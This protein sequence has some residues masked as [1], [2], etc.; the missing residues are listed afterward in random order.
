M[1][2]MTSNNKISVLS[3]NINGLRDQQKRLLVF[4]WLK[5]LSFSIIFLQDVHFTELDLNLW[6]QQ[7]GYPVIWS[8]YNA[9]LLTK[10]SMS[11]SMIPYPH[12]DRILCASIVHT[13]NAPPIRVGSIYLPATPTQRLQLLQDLQ[14]CPDP[15]ISLLGGDCNLLANP[16]IDHSPPQT[17]SS[18]TQWSLFQAILQQW[19]LTDLYR[20]H[21][22]Q[23]GPFTHWQNTP[24]ARVGTRIDY[25]FTSPI[26]LPLCDA[27]QTSYCPY[28]DHAS[29]T[30]AMTLSSTAPHGVGT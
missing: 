28:S 17:G 13:Q 20:H 19:S 18:S 1:T 23:L 24:H 4:R 10:S 5:T 29:L 3:L 26:L 6:N 25:L 30:T 2:S 9:I 12:T 16:A 7:W 15:N 8:Y 11:L 27:V 14:F 21:S 22:S